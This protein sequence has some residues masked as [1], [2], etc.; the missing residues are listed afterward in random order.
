MFMLLCTVATLPQFCDL[1]FDPHAWVIYHPWQASLLFCHG[2]GGEIST[3]AV[4]CHSPFDRV[5]LSE[6][7]ANSDI[8]LSLYYLCHHVITAISF[9]A[10][11]GESLPPESHSPSWYKTSLWQRYQNNDVHTKEAVLNALLVLLLFLIRMSVRSYFKQKSGLSDPELIVV[12][13]PVRANEAE[14]IVDKC[15][16]MKHGQYF[17]FM[18]PLNAASSF[19]LFHA[20][21]S[22]V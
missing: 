6:V 12:N 4:Y 22:L 1:S 16:C 5:L 10:A 9:V 21:R 18:T 15:L 17:V 7:F 8:V 3:H 2:G 19:V 14:A 13:M 11:H 20:H